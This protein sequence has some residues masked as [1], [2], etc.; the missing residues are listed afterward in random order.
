MRS[1]KTLSIL[2]IAILFAFPT[3][4]F[5]ADSGVEAV[6]QWLSI[7]V[8]AVGLITAVVLMVDAVL[9]RRV[10]EGSLI[11]D[12]IVY[13]MT[14]VVCLGGSMI[15]RWGVVFLEDS[16]IVDQAA[17]GADLLVTAG[18]ALLA[19]Y[20]YRIRKAMTGYLKAAKAMT[21]S[22]ADESSGGGAEG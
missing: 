20:V 16:L 22:A 15:L 9:L 7:V 5:A 11:A 8:G 10:S 2:T 1:T 13:L 18:M 17:L 21:D 12:N 3:L 6:P 4:A 19:V 14:C